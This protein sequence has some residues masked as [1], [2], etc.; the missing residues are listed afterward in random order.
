V[1]GRPGRNALR[2]NLPNLRKTLG[3][4]DFVIANCENAASGF[5]MTEKIMDEMFGFGI[6]AMT[7]G[8]HIW[9]KK[10]FVGVLEREPRVL[11]P[12]NYPPGAPGIGFG[13]F[14]RQGRKLGVINLMGRAFMSPVDCP[15]RASDSILE[16]MEADAILV[17]FHAEATAEKI[18]L[19]RYLD[20]RVSI[21]AG[22]HTHVQT[23]D[24][25]ILP[26]GTAYITDAGLTGGHGGVIGNRYDSVLAKFLYGV[27]SKF[28]IE[29]SDARL[30][31]I[32]ADIDDETG[33][34]FDIRRVSASAGQ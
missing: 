19:G 34:A 26:G 5:G 7:S 18:A 12:A 17:D 6:D 11:R 30:Q 27:P 1:C 29:S 28:E 33:K 16:S 21:F 8:N 9:D 10:E 20:G 22:T 25:S 2:E 14:E 13:T 15:F 3:P 31:G 4:F 24:E 23:A 32:V